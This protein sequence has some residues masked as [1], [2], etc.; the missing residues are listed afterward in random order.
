[1]GKKDKKNKKG[2]T[3]WEDEIGEEIA[4]TTK[5]EDAASPAGDASPAPETNSKA[6]EE[7]N[8]DDEFGGGLIGALRARKDKKNKKQPQTAS[9]ADG[10]PAGEDGEIRVK[11]KKEKEKEKKEREKQRK[12]EQV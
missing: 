1:M 9:P 4:P 10:T 5:A 3:S 12:K 11:S 8:L 6:P 7:G 2:D